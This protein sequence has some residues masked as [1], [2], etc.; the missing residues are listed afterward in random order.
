MTK[1]VDRKLFDELAKTGAL[2]ISPEE[3]EPLLNELNEQ[4]SVIHQLEAIP[5][6]DA[7]RPVIHGNPYPPEIRCELREDEWKPFP[8]PAEIIAQAPVSR[9]GCVVSPDVVHLRL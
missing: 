8:S 7:I 6:E 4:L 2:K 1:P 3:A 9:E 5:L